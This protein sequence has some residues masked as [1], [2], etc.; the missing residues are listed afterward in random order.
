MI[1]IASASPLASA[2]F[3]AARPS[4][5]ASS[6]LASTSILIRSFSAFCAFALLLL[7]IQ[8]LEQI[9]QKIENQ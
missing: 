2:M 4:A 7:W 5:W 6:C 8:W 3:A 9:I 1:A